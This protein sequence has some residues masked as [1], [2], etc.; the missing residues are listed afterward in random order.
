MDFLGFLRYE[1]SKRIGPGRTLDDDTLWK[2]LDMKSTFEGGDMGYFSSDSKR[3][4]QYIED[5]PTF[6]QDSVSFCDELTT[7]LHQAIANG[8]DKSCIDGQNGHI[9]RLWDYAEA[10]SDNTIPIIKDINHL[11]DTLHDASKQ[12]HNKCIRTLLRNGAD[13]N[14]VAGGWTPLIYACNG[15]HNEAIMIL[16]KYGAN[17]NYKIFDGRTPLH[18]VANIGNSECMMTLLDHSTEGINYKDDRGWTPLHEVGSSMICA[19]ILLEYGAH[20]NEPDHKG[21]T[22]LHWRASAGNSEYI[23]FLLNN[24][25]LVNVKDHEGRTPLHIAVLDSY[26][27]TEAIKILLDYGAD[28]YETTNKGSNVLDMA[29]KTNREFIDDYLVTHMIKDPGHE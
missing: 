3:T 1:K 2:W 9:F 12:G 29:R 14:E 19:K 24:G 10:H 23:K 7:A 22:P 11:C 25:A 17:A 20:I 27:N 26:C 6:D 15:G 13:V 8:F 28:V 18:F 21:L 5:L 4:L 16:L